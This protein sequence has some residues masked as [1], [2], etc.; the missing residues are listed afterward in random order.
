MTDEYSGPGLSRIV[1]PL[2]ETLSQMVMD[3]V[4]G[5]SK[6]QLEMD[7]A[8]L[9]SCMKE[10][11]SETRAAAVQLK[12]ED[13]E[14]VTELTN[15]VKRITGAVS[16]FCNGFVA[17]LE[18]PNSRVHH[19]FYAKSCKQVEKAINFLTLKVSDAI[20]ALLVILNDTSEYRVQRLT[21][22][23]LKSMAE[24]LKLVKAEYPS[25]SKV[26]NLTLVFERD[27]K[28]V[29]SICLKVLSKTT[30]E[31]LKQ[32]LNKSLDAL[33]L[34]APRIGDNLLK[35]S[36]DH[37]NP[38]LRAQSEALLMRAATDVSD[39]YRDIVRGLEL[40]K[41]AYFTKFKKTLSHVKSAVASAKDLQKL[42][43]T[44]VE[45]IRKGEYTPGEWNAIINEIKRQI[46]L[47]AEKT[48]VAMEGVQDTVCFFLQIFSYILLEQ[49]LVFRASN[50]GF[51][52]SYSNLPCAYKKYYC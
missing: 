38:R 13:P 39:A 8:Q 32:L 15:S 30:Y 28:A 18:T 26:N 29:V 21:D 51:G 19:E 2:V 1:D 37:D 12:R 7:V 52:R 43:S 10:L 11:T 33:E 17:Y 34:S 47:L 4:S 48:K 45:E 9:T 42:A 50:V 36:E 31:P 24:S 5:A 22:K 40:I 27:N 3:S 35:I 23:A 6:V 41:P 16:A 49:T 46:A 20:S 25:V 14:L 44:V